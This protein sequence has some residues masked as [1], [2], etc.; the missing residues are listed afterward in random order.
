MKISFNWLKSYL[1]FDL[2]PERTSEILTD[3]GLEIEGLQK[4]EEIK[5]GLDGVVVGEVISCEPH[6]DADRLK[7]TMVSLG[8]E[9][10][11]IVCG[12]PNIRKR[13]K[14]LVATVG[15][16]LHPNNGETFK[17]KK[18]KI[19]GVESFGM[20]CAED[21]LGLGASHEGIL[22]LPDEITTGTPAASFYNL[23]T[24]FQLEIGLTP[25]R[26]D[27][28]GHIGVARDLKA[29]L[30]FHENQNLS[31][32]LPDTE[33]IISEKKDTDRITIEIDDPK[34][35]PRYI[36]A[37]MDNV[38]IQ[39]SPKWLK[40]RLKSIGLEP[41]NNVVD[42]S[43]FIM[44][45]YGTP[46]H[47][48]D[49]S[50]L[51]R[52]IIVKKA[53]K[54]SSFKT[55]DGIERKLNGEELMI[56][57]EDKNLCIAG[58]FG[59]LDSGVSENTTSIFLES[60]I[61]NAT[62]VRKTSKAHAIQTDASFRFERGVDPTCTAD[63]MKRA[64]SL[65]QELTGGDLT[66]KPV[67]VDE[68]D[69]SEKKICFSIDFLNQRLGTALKTKEVI[70]ILENLDF[71]CSIDRNENIQTIVPQYRID[72]TRPEDILEEVL[73]IYGFNK[74]QLPK[75]WNISFP[76]EDG[77]NTENL[78]RRTSEWFVANGFSE[79][80][81]NSLRR[82]DLPESKRKSVE[83]LNPLS[84]ELQ[85][86][87][88]SLYFGLLENLTYNQ[89][90]QQQVQ[91][92]FEFGKSYFVANDQY[93]ETR[94]LAFVLCG[95]TDDLSW[96]NTTKDLN[97][98]NLKQTCES[99]ITKLGLKSKIEEG[100]N[101]EGFFERSY[102]YKLGKEILIEFGQASLTYCKKAGIK[103]K[104]FIAL[105]NWDKLL[106][107]NN[108]NISFKELPKTF[109]VRRDFS[110]ILDEHVEYAAIEKLG[111]A[112]N[113]K[114]L[115]DISLFDVYEGDKLP[116][117][118]KSYAVSFMFQDEHETLKDGI[119]DPIMEQIRMK[120]K[121]ELGAELRA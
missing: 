54:G 44:Y 109:F 17:I 56:T 60:A 114:L 24:D 23:Y 33:I 21:E 67:V 9:N 30:N 96:Q 79:V 28:M 19:R 4:F 115:K 80:M 65:L 88:K 111:Y 90:R 73:R 104:V 117:G 42:V 57:S 68:F 116:K 40:N 13:Q 74:V 14:V 71:I 92:L 15:T 34:L 26:C 110:L 53:N 62:S 51:G 35:C 20:I 3:T 93:I 84:K 43:N 91:R 103:S 46:M 77:K 48:F 18:A 11:Q 81:N 94:E 55:L 31:L 61:F 100:A 7:V 106:K 97:F 45:E 76:L 113:K 5:G 78:Q 52:N 72:V 6:P 41:I 37:I 12:A 87:R 70:S 8:E 1:D 75:K 64:I 86:M 32:R 102:T 59:G 95:K 83:I 82:N 99:L 108:S 121:N 58:V 105:C 25:N 39:E 63:A 50:Q 22:I 101:E 120:L 16:I 107:Y 69:S 49:R 29:F 47:A 118:K 36:G 2:T 119:I 38:K 85:T 10:V 112:A 66:M 98:Y 89:N 27:A